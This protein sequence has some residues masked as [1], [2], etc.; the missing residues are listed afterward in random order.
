[1][2]RRDLSSM[3]WVFASHFYRDPV[4]PGTMMIEG[5]L[6]LAGF[7]GAYAGGKGKGRAARVDDIRFLAEVTPDDK[8]ITYRIDI[9]R[10]S[11]D[12][13][14]LVAE[15]EAI[16]RGTARATAGK[17]WVCAHRGLNGDPGRT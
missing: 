1:V 8:E 9:R 7:Y 10:C 14:L 12:H 3:S 11:A 13:T 15:G 2:A 6:Q 17:L 5:L 16:A 4:M